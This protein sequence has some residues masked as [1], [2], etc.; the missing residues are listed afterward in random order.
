EKGSPKAPWL[1][2]W[3]DDSFVLKDEHREIVFETETAVA[4]HIIDLSEAF[5][6]GTICLNVASGL[7]RFKQNQEALSALRTLVDAGLQHDPTYRA[8]IGRRSVRFIITGAVLFLIC[9]GLFAGYCC[10]AIW[11]PDPPA[12]SWVHTFGRFIKYGLTVLLAMTLVGVG[13]G[14][15]GLR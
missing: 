12:D 9:G 1:L 7:L 13:L 15:S 4:H 2:K 14:L 6:V 3:D 5:V 11:W 8:E 10:Y